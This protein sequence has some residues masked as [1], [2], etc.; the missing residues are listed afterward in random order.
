MK[1]KVINSLGIIIIHFF[2]MGLIMNCLYNWAAILATI[3]Y[4]IIITYLLYTS[5][6]NKTDAIFSLI[7][8]SL[9]LFFSFIGFHF[10]NTVSVLMYWLFPLFITI[11]PF[12]GFSLIEGIPDKIASLIPFVISLLWTACQVR[13]LY[14]FYKTK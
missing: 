12:S 7:Y 8:T 14:Y 11:S 4:I 10:R 5:N 6:E 9:L 3:M 13:N 2:S 1:L